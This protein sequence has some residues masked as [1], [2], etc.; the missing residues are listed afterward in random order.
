MSNN[1]EIHARL[2]IPTQ[3]GLY[4]TEPVAYSEIYDGISKGI[5][6]DKPGY[7]FDFY[8]SE[9]KKLLSDQQHFDILMGKKYGESHRGYLEKIPAG[10]ERDLAYE[11]A[12][13]ASR[14]KRIMQSQMTRPSMLELFE[15]PDEIHR[16]HS[17]LHPEVQE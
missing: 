6:P 13:R 9:A 17:Y 16:Y 2:G 14:L 3:S 7:L 15:N 12:E 8:Q 5:K 1:D 11:L 10:P 4:E